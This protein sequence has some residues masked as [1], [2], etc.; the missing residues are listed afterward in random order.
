[1]C[2]RV[3]LRLTVGGRAEQLAH[4]LPAEKS[5]IMARFGSGQ[6]NRMDAIVKWRSH[7]LPALSCHA[8]PKSNRPDWAEPS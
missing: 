4:P 2:V 7:F 5:T 3:C 8:L 1:M 6:R